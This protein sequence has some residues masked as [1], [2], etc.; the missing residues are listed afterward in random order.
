MYDSLQ[1]AMNYGDCYTCGLCPIKCQ[2]LGYCRMIEGDKHASNVYYSQNP[3][4]YNCD[5][6]YEN[7]F[8]ALDAFRRATATVR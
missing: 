2:K 8:K 1:D 6:V 3:N 5:P 7:E 4:I